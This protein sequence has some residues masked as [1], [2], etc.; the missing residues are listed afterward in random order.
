MAKL[1][2]KPASPLTFDAKTN[3]EAGSAATPSV[4]PPLGAEDVVVK[5]P[6]E[7]SSLKELN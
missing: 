4:T 2:M 6:V 5:V 3:F 1:S 7:V